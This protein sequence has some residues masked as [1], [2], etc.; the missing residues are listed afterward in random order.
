MLFRS[1]VHTAMVYIT[2]L[3]CVQRKDP[4]DGQRNCPKRVEFH[5]K[6]KFE[7]LVHLVN[8]ILSNLFFYPF[9]RSCNPYS[10]KA[11]IRPV[12]LTPIL[13]AC[14]QLSVPV[15]I[16]CPFYCVPKHGRFIAQESCI[17]RAISW[18]QPYSGT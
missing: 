6:N 14:V 10:S 15:I 11:Q 9:V 16:R 3:L 7:N 5:S 18:Q 4:D 13:Y 2:D 1:T 17:R 8:F 12:A